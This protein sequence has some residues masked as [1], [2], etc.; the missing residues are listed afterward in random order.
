MSS[1]ERSKQLHKCH[2]CGSNFQQYDLEIHFLSCNSDDDDTFKEEEIRNDFN[3]QEV[4]LKNDESTFKSN[5]NRFENA[6]NDCISDNVSDNQEN[7]IVLWKDVYP[8][9]VDHH[10]DSRTTPS[11]ENQVPESIE[12][13][14]SKTL[15]INHDLSF[16]VTTEQ[17]L[18]QSVGTLQENTENQTGH[19]ISPD[20]ISATIPTQRDYKIKDYNCECCGKSFSQAE[21]LKKHIH[22]VHEGHK[23][24]KCISCGKLFSKAGNLKKHTHTVH[25][26]RKDHK[27]G[28]CGKSFFLAN[29]LKNHENKI[30]KE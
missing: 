16:N 4:F 5:S 3:D 26:G 25:E 29:H 21:I 19:L 30:H 24:F 11:T 6:D 27:C 12:N 13:S 22:R 10:A 14:N 2:I 20:I 15:A 28:F 7:L 18:N 23:D 8:P 17:F 9:E 1:S